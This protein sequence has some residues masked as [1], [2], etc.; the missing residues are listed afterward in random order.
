MSTVNVAELIR[1]AQV[2][3]VHEFPVVILGDP[4]LLLEVVAQRSGF[5]WELRI[6]PGLLEIEPIEVEYFPYLVL[7]TK[8]RPDWPK[9]AGRGPVVTP[10]TLYTWV[11]H[12]GSK[13]IEV[14]GRD[15]QK[16]FDY[17]KSA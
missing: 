17:P 14:I 7:E 10:S 11:T 13:G 2:N 8:I 15:F 12:F 3:E 4:Q 16:K 5:N 1:L 6:Q 9:H